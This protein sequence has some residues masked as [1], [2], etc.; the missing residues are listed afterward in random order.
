MA[1]NRKVMEHFSQP[2]NVGEMQ[3]PD[4]VGKAGN[5]MDGDVVVIYIKVKDDVI[6]D[7]KFQAFGCAAAIASSSIF[8]EL[9]KGKKISEALQ[10]NRQQVSNELEG[11]P[12]NKIDCSIIAPDALE[13]AVRNFLD[14]QGREFIRNE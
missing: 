6:A 11:L 9:A 8:T 7:I 14:K 5:T 12:P 1:Y 2:R 4:G 13:K 3:D 10:I